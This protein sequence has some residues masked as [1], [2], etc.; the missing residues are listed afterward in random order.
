MNS[1]RAALNA[2]STKPSDK[3]SDKPSKPSTPEASKPS[4][5]STSTSKPIST[6]KPSQSSS[7]SSTPSINTTDQY[8]GRTSFV[9]SRPTPTLVGQEA[10]RGNVTGFNSAL[11]PKESLFNGEI[12]QP[13]AHNMMNIVSRMQTTLNNEQLNPT[14]YASPDYKPSTLKSADNTQ[15]NPNDEKSTIDTKE[16][17]SFIEKSRRTAAS[18]I[19]RTESMSPEMKED[20]IYTTGAGGFSRSLVGAE[21][22][23]KIYN[24]SG[25][26]INAKEA[27]DNLGMATSATGIMY[28]G[29]KVI[30]ESANLFN[31]D[32]KGKSITRGLGLVSNGLATV[33][34]IQEDDT[35]KVLE[36]GSKTLENAVKLSADLHK[37]FD[38]KIAA[39]ENSLRPTTQ[40]SRR[41]EGLQGR[42]RDAQE[43]FARAERQMSNL[44]ESGANANRVRNRTNALDR[45][46]AHLESTIR[47][48]QEFAEQVARRT[49][50]GT[51]LKVRKTLVQGLGTIG[52]MAPFVDIPVSLGMGANTALDRAEERGE[53]TDQNKVAVGVGG[54]IGG[55]IGDKSCELAG[56]GIGFM[57]GG[58]VG[59]LIGLGIGSL[60]G[61]VV[62]DHTADFGG[63]VGA[64]I[65]ENGT[66]QHGTLSNFQ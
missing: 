48:Q 52:K 49:T 63:Q 35:G 2:L 36:S 13:Q 31:K 56:A 17:A 5:S 40:E 60:V 1:V 39:R 18:I 12:N 26:L 21:S 41:L 54:A 19:N 30:T 58:P 57:I 66:Y 51:G 10:G 28:N 25:D 53:L 11:A 47:E 50:P 8:V 4:T 37:I 7:S 29:G 27:N 23:L 38:P 62:S 59:A 6:Q 14:G 55:L 33:K 44:P 43:Q 22:I 24:G 3:P 32:L 9:S 46:R 61:A 42:V 65:S 64:Y 15:N 45:T 34:A 20:K 16:T